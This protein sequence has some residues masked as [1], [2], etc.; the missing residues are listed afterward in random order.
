MAQ[1]NAGKLRICWG[2]KRGKRLVCKEPVTDE[3]IIEEVKRLIEELK[4]RIERHRDKL[5]S[6]AFID[7]LINLLERWLEEHKNDKGKKIKEA[8]KIARKMIKLLRKLRRRWVEEYWKQLLELIEMLKR[9]AI[10]VIVTGG[11]G[12]KSLMVHIYNR[13]VAVKVARV[14]KSGGVAISLS[15]SKLDGDDIK[16][17]NTFSDKELLK[18]IQHGWEMTDGSVEHGHPAMGTSQPWQVVLWSLCYP[19]KIRMYINGIGINEDGVS[20]MWRLIAKDH[21]AKP[22]RG[23]AEEVERL[24]TERLKVFLAPAV[25]S[26]GNINVSKRYMRLIMGLAKYDLWLGIIERL[27]NELGFTIRLREYK[28]EVEVKSSKAVKLARDWLSVPDIREL[29]ELGASL[30][31]GEKL[32]RIIELASKDVKERGSSSI[33]IPGTSISMSIHIDKQCKVELRAWRRDEK[34]ALKLVE[35]LRRA[36]YNPSM[37]VE[38][39]SHVVSITYSNICES[40]LKPIVCR[41]LGE[42]LENEKRRE[43]ITKAIQNLKCFNDT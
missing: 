2:V 10:D 29:I 11:N 23:V 4:R 27:I 26:D 18:A 21:R 39:G 8:K 7:E 20:I 36:G 14:T 3:A 43:R 38:K 33:T 6:A 32:R 41:K 24:G 34:E 5:G 9:N 25:W 16:I 19:G 37:Y 35:E 17:A 28:V 13:E 22:K 42:W 40:P 1:V 12:E 15:L 30:P 31:G